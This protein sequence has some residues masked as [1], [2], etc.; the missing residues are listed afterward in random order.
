MP[1]E[2][3]WEDLLSS[4]SRLQ[5]ILP[6]AVLVGGTAA[7]MHVRFKHLRASWQN[8]ETVKAVCIKTSQ[9]LASELERPAAEAR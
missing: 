4:A 1:E 8:W 2:P 7:A 9:V 5:K 3:I 6:G